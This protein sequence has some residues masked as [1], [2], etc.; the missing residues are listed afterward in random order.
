MPEITG[1]LLAAGQSRR[2]GD[3]KLLAEIDQRALILHAAVSLSPCSRLLAVVRRQDHALHQLLQDRSIELVFNDQSTRGKGSSIACAVA[4]SRHSH[5]WCVLPADMPFIRPSTT[6]AVITAL[7]NNAVLA[8]PFYK[9]K[10][11]HPVGFSHQLMRDLLELESEPGARGIVAEQIKHLVKIDSGDAAVL[12][13]IDTRQD[14]QKYQ[15]DDAI[16]TQ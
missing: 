14:L 3:N 1:V 15:L 12:I 6:Q 13:D 5:G 11:G 10:R 8:A 7:Q 16:S 4:A 2:F 9:G